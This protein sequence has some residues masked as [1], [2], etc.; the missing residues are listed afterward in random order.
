[1]TFL[2]FLPL[3]IDCGISFASDWYYYNAGI[4]M[5][6]DVMLDPRSRLE[7]KIKEVR[8]VEQKY[9][10][11]FMREGKERPLS[12]ITPSL[13]W[14]V[15]TIAHALGADIKFDPKMDPTAV[16]TIDLS[17][18]DPLK[19]LKLPDME[20]AL[21]PVLNDID[22]YKEMG[23]SRNQI[24][25]PDMQGPLNIALETFGDGKVLSLISN[26]K[27]ESVVRKIL[28]YTK[29]AF[30]QAN[31]IIRRELNRPKKLN[32]TVSGCTYYYISPRAWKKFIIPVLHECVENL[33]PISLHHCGVANKD[34]IDA[35]SEIKWQRVEFGFG[36]DISYVRKTIVNEKL[37]PMLI[38]C[39]VSP[40]RMLNQPARQI[41]EDVEW[42]IEKGKGGPQTIAVV[43]CPYKTPDENIYT[44]W[45]TVQAYNKMK[46]EEDEEF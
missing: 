8:F 23:F 40:Y 28:E 19:D 3:Y 18:I 36:T 26:K 12:Q 22:V 46:E 15:V 9:P 45:D 7:N 29:D 39:R 31:K 30:I 10:E 27:K 4:S 33:G 21:L 5:D 35:Y 6:K 37:G 41:K 13:G 25:M 17:K 1:M 44:L 38:S 14:G 32:W 43:G 16:P 42:L 20:E 2:D 34:Q 24:G 11:I